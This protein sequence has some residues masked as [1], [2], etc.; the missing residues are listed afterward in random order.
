VQDIKLIN[1]GIV[2]EKNGPCGV[3]AAV[4][5]VLLACCLEREGELN[6]NRVFS[7]EEFVDALALIVER[8]NECGVVQVALWKNEVGDDVLIHEMTKGEEIRRFVVCFLLW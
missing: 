5:A 4:N 1:L 8:C 6:K 3:L 7:A 2:Q